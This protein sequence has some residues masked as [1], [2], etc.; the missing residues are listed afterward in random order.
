MDNKKCLIIFV[1][2]LLENSSD[3]D[4]PLT[5]SR[6]AF[7]ISN[8]YTCDR[9][10]VG[11][12]IKTLIK[13]GYPIVKTPKGYYLDKKKFTIEEKDYIIN[14]IKTNDEKSDEEK[15]IIINR[16]SEILDYIYRK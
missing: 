7:I 4:H 14:C 3:K 9:K 10:T 2:K 5:Q 8:K 6:I 16:L 1:L 15:Q 11:R 12:N 13:I